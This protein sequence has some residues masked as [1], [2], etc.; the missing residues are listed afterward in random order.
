MMGD[1]TVGLSGR[2]LLRQSRPRLLS[3]PGHKQMHSNHCCSVQCT[4]AART[5]SSPWTHSKWSGTATCM[6]TLLCK[7]HLITEENTL[8]YFNSPKKII[9]PQPQMEILVGSH[10]PPPAVLGLVKITANTFPHP[11]LCWLCFGG[12]A[13]RSI[14]RHWTDWVRETALNLC[15]RQW[16][17]NTNGQVSMR[18]RSRGSLARRRHKWYCGLPS[19][20]TTIRPVAQ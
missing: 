10:A 9:L 4:I 5:R 19:G 11:R 17:E 8:I 2:D 13:T 12:E 20:S 1:N 15:R 16:T 18:R 14:D 6:P 3:C 7:M